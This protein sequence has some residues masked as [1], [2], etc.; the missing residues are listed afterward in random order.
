MPRL[1]EANTTSAFNKVLKGE[2]VSKNNMNFQSPTTSCFKRKQKTSQLQI[3]E[4]LPLLCEVR[5][6]LLLLRPRIPPRDP[7]ILSTSDQYPKQTIQLFNQPTS[8]PT[9]QQ[10]TE[11]T[12]KTSKP[13]QTKPNQPTNNQTNNVC[14]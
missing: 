9:N 1:V 6:V 3:L 2:T 11:R 5:S 4:F 10:T 12:S 14:I 8:Q 13:N 7:S